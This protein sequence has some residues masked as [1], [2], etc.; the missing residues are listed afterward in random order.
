MESHLNKRT[1]THYKESDILDSLNNHIKLQGEAIIPTD[2]GTFLMKAYAKRPDETMPHFALIKEPFDLNLPVNVR[3]HSECLT[4]DIFHS[5]RCECGEQLTYSMDYISKNTGIIIYLRQEG[6]GIGI[7]NKLHAYVK[8]DEG[9]DTAQANEA[10]GLS[11]DARTYEDAVAI[12]KDLDIKE[13]NLLTNNPEKI[14]A[15]N[16]LGIKVKDRIPVIVKPK[17]ANKQ[18]LETKKNVFGHWL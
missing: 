10:L 1:L 9:L 5:N 2:F 14:N 8:Q 6:R 7:I 16:D 18:Y 3:I 13:I 17:K 12:L 11:I 4:G 15:L